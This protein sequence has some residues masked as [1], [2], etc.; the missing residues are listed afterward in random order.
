MSQAS[1]HVKWCIEKAKKEIEEAKKFGKAQKHRGLVE[2]KPNLD[3]AVKHIEK[4]DHNLR[5]ALYVEKGGFSDWAVSAS[6]YCLYHCMLAILA[7]HGYE[8]RNQTCT[9]AAIEFLKE[10]G[11]ISLD[12]K[13][14]KTLKPGMG[15]GKVIEMREEYT[16]G[17]EIA[18]QEA[19]IKKLIEL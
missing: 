3:A 13:F 10:E 4:A 16:Y 7:K 14:I 8:S 12:D 6:F 17:F 5:M 18:V 19:D 15:E 11:K 2:I 9:M 1:N